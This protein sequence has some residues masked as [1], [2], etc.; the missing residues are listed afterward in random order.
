MTEQTLPK[1]M[2]T[3]RI[4]VG[5]LQHAYID[6]DALSPENAC[7][8]LQARLKS[9]ND[10]EMPDDIHPM[11]SSWNDPDD[12]GEGWIITGGDIPVD[13]AK[14]TVVV[15]NKGQLKRISISSELA[16]LFFD[17]AQGEGS[18]VDDSH[19]EERRGGKKE[20]VHLDVDRIDDAVL[21]L[22]YLNLH[23]SGAAWKSFDWGATDRL[24]EKGLISNPVGKAKSVGLTEEGV[25]RAKSLFERMFVIERA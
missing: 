1:K 25:E 17:Q 18:A 3:Y 12:E 2:H 8:R 5:R 15:W 24:F 22:L 4:T 14:E 9:D 23:E 6:I 16:P 21:A 19:M 7:K 11:L 10:L 13:H 20:T